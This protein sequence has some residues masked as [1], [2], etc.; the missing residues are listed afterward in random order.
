G[1]E[2]LRS[3]KVVVA[4]RDGDVSRGKLGRG[5][6]R[7]FR[8]RKGARHSLGRVDDS[9][10]A[11]NEADVD[12]IPRGQSRGGLS[13]LSRRDTVG[14]AYKLD[15]GRGWSAALER[16]GHILHG[17]ALLQLDQLRLMQLLAMVD[18]L[19]RHCS[20]RHAVRRLESKV[21]GSYGDG[22]RFGPGGF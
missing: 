4:Q 12:V 6:G 14:A 15:P 20:G 13:S 7:R 11:G 22:S 2:R 5:W 9:I 10:R 1:L 21:A 8:H 16:L 3:L 17:L 19:H 18:Q